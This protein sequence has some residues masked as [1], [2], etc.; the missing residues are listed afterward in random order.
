MRK[1]YIN[2]ELIEKIDEILRYENRPMSIKNIVSQLH[3]YYEI[4]KSPQIVLRHLNILKNRKGAREIKD[5]S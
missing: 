4:K 3:K 5:G 1:K 2:E